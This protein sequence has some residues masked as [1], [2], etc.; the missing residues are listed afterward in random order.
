[1]KLPPHVAAM[2]AP[3]TI[4]PPVT[5]YLRTAAA[6]NAQVAA[7]AAAAKLRAADDERREA[8][9][10]SLADKLTVEAKILADLKVERAAI[11]GERR[12][13]E[14]DL[15]P[16]R[17]LAT[18]IGADNETVLRWFILVVALLLDPAAVLPLFAPTSV[19]RRS[20]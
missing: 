10:N 1:V 2:D 17:Y 18:L 4:D 12:T 15:G 16:V 13:V 3:Q 20:A 6:I 11:E 5:G 9:C 19:R 7:L 14:A 8:K